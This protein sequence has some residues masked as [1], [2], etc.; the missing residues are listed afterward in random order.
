MIKQIIIRHTFLV[1]IFNYH[2]NSSY[3]ILFG[4]FAKIY[5]HIYP[6][7]HLHS[8]AS[9]GQSLWYSRRVEGNDRRSSCQR[10]NRSPG[11]GTQSRL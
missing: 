9:V 10:Y 1:T 8:V 5:L 4:S 6:I 11:R 7:S 3:L 2:F